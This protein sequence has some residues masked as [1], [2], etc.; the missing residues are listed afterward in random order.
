MRC[1]QDLSWTTAAAD[2]L[3]CL[4][5]AFPD[6]ANSA[7]F[8]NLEKEIQTSLELVQQ[9]ASHRQSSVAAVNETDAINPP[10]EQQ[11]E[12]LNGTSKIL[13]ANI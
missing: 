3:S 5:D 1:L 7:T 9:T 2:A 11:D 12:L 13:A 4:K 8:K 6:H 10:N